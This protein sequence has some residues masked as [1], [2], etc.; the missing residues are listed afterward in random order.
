MSIR[1]DS[2]GCITSFRQSL[3]DA[4]KDLQQELLNEAK[5]GMQTPEGANSLHDEEIKDI[6]NVIT[7]SIVGGAWA[8]MDEFGKGSEMQR[9]NPALES[10]IGG[11]LWNP[12]RMGHTIVGR[13][14]GSYTNIFGERA[15]SSG[16]YEGRYIE[17]IVPSRPPSKA[18]QTAARW[19][20][21]EDGRMREKIKDTIKNFPFHKFIITDKK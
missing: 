1:F 3:I 4:M 13:P 2:Q 21:G 12:K 11:D 6:A 10:Y 14:E 19:M 17:H 16:R 18:I 15:Y 5:Q 8:A 7:A 20:S 9:D